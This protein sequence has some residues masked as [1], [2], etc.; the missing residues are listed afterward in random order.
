MRS[1]ACSAR[2][3]YV[4]GALWRGPRAAGCSAS[5]GATAAAPKEGTKKPEYDKFS[6]YF[7]LD[8]GTGEASGGVYHLQGNE[9]V[10]P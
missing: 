5:G 9:A 10:R 8:N 1:K 4:K 2:A 6:A 3:L 7:N